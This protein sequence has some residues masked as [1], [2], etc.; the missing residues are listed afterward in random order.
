MAD[1]KDKDNTGSRDFIRAMVANDLETGKY[2]GRVVTRFPPEPNGYL[3]I[4]HEGPLAAGPHR[5]FHRSPRAR[6]AGAAVGSDL[7]L[8][9]HN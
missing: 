2:N 4:G 6:G 5:C 1:S 9:P 3:H 8:Y 7:G